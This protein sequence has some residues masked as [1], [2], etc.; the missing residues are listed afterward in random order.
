[1]GLRE[2]FDDSVS[3]I[4]EGRSTTVV[5]IDIFLVPAAFP[6]PCLAQSEQLRQYSPY[7]EPCRRVFFSWPSFP[8]A[9]CN[10]RVGREKEKV[11]QRGRLTHEQAAE[12]R[13]S[14]LNHGR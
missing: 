3:S 8:V 7:L 10:V 6:K 14:A 13:P 5:E 12:N 9:R 11:S 4:G 2:L 1:M